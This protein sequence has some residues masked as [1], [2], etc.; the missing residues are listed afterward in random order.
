MEDPKSQSV[1]NIS[2]NRSENTVQVFCLVIFQRIYIY[3]FQ[4]I[5]IYIFQRIYI[6]IFTII[7]RR[8]RR[9]TRR[10]KRQIIIYFIYIYIDICLVLSNMF[11]PSLPIPMKCNDERTLQT[12]ILWGTR[13][14]VPQTRDFFFKPPA[15]ISKM[16]TWPK[17]TYHL[18]I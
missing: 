11:F 7:R 12:H 15:G 4:R 18:V 14:F 5:Y 9:R 3:I 6:Y 2:K 10:R 1:Q 13:V 8:T 16:S 17:K